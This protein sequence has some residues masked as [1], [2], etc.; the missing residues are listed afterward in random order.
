[1]R[2][3]LVSPNCDADANRALIEAELPDPGFEQRIRRQYRKTRK[4]RVPHTWRTRP[5]PFGGVWEEMRSWLESDPERTSKSLLL[6]FQQRRVREW[7]RQILQTFD[8]EWLEL[9]RVRPAS[10]SAGDG[11]CGT[12]GRS[13]TL[14]NSSS[15]P[16]SHSLDGGKNSPV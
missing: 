7:R 2:A 4:Q 1:M 6:E 10:A 5:D 12:G 11:A 15:F 8:G 13:A 14:E 16:L 3:A 9:D